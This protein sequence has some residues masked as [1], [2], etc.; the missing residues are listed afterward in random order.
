MPFLRQ[1]DRFV[2]CLRDDKEFAEQ[3]V[4][5]REFALFDTFRSEFKQFLSSRRLPTSVCDEDARWHSF[6]SLYAGVIED[7]SLSILAQ[8]GDLRLVSGVTFT[9]GRSVPGAYL[10]FDLNWDIHLLGDPPKTL[11]CNFRAFGTPGGTEM[12]L[13]GCQLPPGGIPR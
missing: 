4:M 12:L 13:H 6:L 10:P 3:G 8:P 1:V 9:K 11:K 2:E 5:F 7:G